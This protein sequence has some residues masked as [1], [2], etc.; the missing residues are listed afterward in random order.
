MPKKILLVDI[1][2]LFYRAFFALPKT[3]TDKSGQTVNA[4]YGTCS[5]LLSLF[6]LEKPDYI[7]GFRDE[8]EKTF[9]H[10]RDENYKAQ[11]PPMPDELSSQMPIIFEM[12]ENFGFPVLSQV[13]YEA[14]DCI[15]TI[16][17]T[18][19]QNKDNEINILSSDHDLM[20]LVRDNIYILKP[21]SG[22][23]TEKM[24][25]DKVKEHTGVYPEQIA[26]FKALAGDSSD[27]LAGVAGIGKKG[28]AELLTEY[29][30][31]ENILE[32]IPNIKGKKG[33]IL[34]QEKEQ[35]LHTQK[36]T[37]LHTDVPECKIELSEADI[38]N[39]D[40]QQV[41]EFFEKYSFKSLIRRLEQMNLIND[42]KKEPSNE[43]MSFF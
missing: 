23:K 7:V 38:Q 34:A 15:A 21:L 10:E 33:E 26:D 12:Q 35:A 18:F 14:D 1:P 27:N 25:R 42:S 19:A 40:W 28:A 17:T 9:R 6:E 30:T 20:G 43:Q 31:L 36:M 5:A 39:I 11:R 16:A 8:R 32:N 24:N 3:L 4:V 22:G 13:G 37:Q 41:K 2:N 29:G